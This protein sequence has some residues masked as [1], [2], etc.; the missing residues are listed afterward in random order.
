CLQLGH[1][2][3]RGSTRPAAEGVDLPLGDG[4]WSLLSASPIPYSARSPV[5]KAMDRDDMDRLCAAFVDA[6]TAASAFDVLE[7]NMAQGYVLASFLSPLTNRREDEYGGSL[8]GRLRYPLV[9]LDA[10]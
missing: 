8:D 6:A 9:V 7:V 5:P 4:G 10:V 1:A 2:G 3:P